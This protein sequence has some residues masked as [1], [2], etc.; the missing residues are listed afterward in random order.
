MMLLTLLCAAGK[1]L[2]MGRLL[3]SDTSK[4]R[5]HSLFCHGCLNVITHPV[6]IGTC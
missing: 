2:G 4:I 1:S 5:T 6:G 3:K